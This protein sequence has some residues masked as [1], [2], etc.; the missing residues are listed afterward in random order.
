MTVLIVS[1][2]WDWSAEQVAN[3]LRDRGVRYAWLDVGA[4]PLDLALAAELDDGAWSGGLTGARPVELREVTSVF[5]RRPSDFTLPAGMSGPERR[6]A[7]AQARV[8]LGGILSSLPA[9]WI[10]HPAVLADA[11]Y[12][13]R[14]LVTASRVGMAVPPTLVTNQ[15]EAARKFAARYGDLIVKPLAEP[16][17]EEAGSH[18][19]VWTRKVIAAD[20]DDLAGVETTAHLF[21]QWVPKRFEVRLTVV[22]DRMFPVAIHAGSE[23]ARVDWRSDYDAL[24]Y[25]LVECPPDI[26]GQVA[27]YCRAFGLTYAA[28]DFVVTTGGRWVFLECNGAGQWGWLAEELDLPIAAALA[29]ELTKE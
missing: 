24:S 18:T 13:P 10:N 4:F 8:G 28:F 5:Y 16:I 23:Q 3:Q 9:R 17:V 14:Q 27:D 2:P 11:E 26:A 20:L 25:E 29:D 15:A 19:A 1:T 7:R 22:G 21:Q 6:F 12:K